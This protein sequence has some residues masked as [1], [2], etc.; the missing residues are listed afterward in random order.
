[1]TD[2]YEILGLPRDATPEQIKKAYRRLAREL[3]PDVAGTDPASEERFKDVS[4]AY[5]VLGNP[6]KRRAYDMGADPAS[7]GGGMGGGFGFQDIFETFFGAAAG[8]APRGPVARARRGQDAL[9][10]LDLDLAETAFGV[11]R[12]VQ[13]DTAVLCPTCG[14][15]CC[16]PGTSPRTCEVC[17]GRGSVQRVARSFLGQVMTTQPCAACHGFGTVIPEPCTEC[18]GEGRVRSRR[19]LSVDVPAGVDTGTRIKLTGQG[20]VGP[21]GGPAGDVYLEV[22]ERKHD[23]FVR[24]GDDLH[25]TL[26]VPMTAAALGTVLSMETL[27][28]PQEVDL[29]PGTQPG[30]VVTLRGL[31]IGHLHVGGRGDLHV[32]VE[33]QV[34]T[35]ADDEQAELLRRL[36]VLRGEERPEARFAAANPG[37]FAKLR[38]KLAGR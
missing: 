24:R 30:E 26:Q 17:G 31:G 21:A 12:E 20:E 34:P 10:R 33:V 28:G 23:T 35:P 18:A 29:R 3:H 2:Y 9:V 11:H 14:G 7:P 15:T 16:R 38:D 36:A 4:R 6:E 27:D 32:H 5:D 13:V 19:T 8:G 37:M 22:R 25:A 1:M